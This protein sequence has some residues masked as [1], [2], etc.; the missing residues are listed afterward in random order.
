MSQLDLKTTLADYKRAGGVKQS[1]LQTLEAGFYPFLPLTK[2][3]ELGIQQK[4]M[5]NSKPGYPNTTPTDEYG[6][7]FLPNYDVTGE[8]E[9]FVKDNIKPTIAES[10][11]VGMDSAGKEMGKRLS[12]IVLEGAS[13]R[14]KVAR[15]TE[16]RADYTGE[17]A[18][19]VLALDIVEQLERKD[20]E[21]G[22]GN[23]DYEGDIDMSSFK[24]SQQYLDKNPQTEQ[25]RKVLDVYK[26]LF[27]GA[28]M[29]MGGV[30]GI[31][32]TAGLYKKITKNVG[33]ISKDADTESINKKF[34]EGIKKVEKDL[35]KELGSIKFTKDFDELEK[36]RD[37]NTHFEARQFLSRFMEILFY[38]QIG[39]IGDKYVYTAPLGT[40]DRTKGYE[41]HANY[42]GFYSVLPTNVGG[43]LKA[44]LT[45]LGVFDV[46]MNA[47]GTIDNFTLKL[48]EDGVGLANQVDMAQIT[49]IST[50]IANERMLD[51]FD[52]DTIGMES[53]NLTSVLSN[54]AIDGNV[55]IAKVLTDSELS[56]AL[57]KSFEAYASDKNPLI[58]EFVKS[59]LR[60]S[61][62]LSK[63]WKR[64]V[65][66]SLEYPTNDRYDWAAQQNF[67]RDG[68]WADGMTN[69]WQAS[70][71]KGTGLSISPYLLAGDL[72]QKDY[73]KM[74]QQQKT[75]PFIRKARRNPFA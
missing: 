3:Y 5:L 45:P 73:G 39:L 31:E 42:A 50:Q 8:G 21:F 15:K 57:L 61:N 19:E 51:K 20:I 25:S 46:G 36:I 49:K 28:G 32:E 63:T 52:S 11:G 66:G 1:I 64:R 38:N 14:P 33:T 43:Q 27:T 53:T 75:M 54:G 71:G 30:L 67:G 56:K 41:G 17:I 48:I 23:L 12:D 62:N 37:N 4:I 55:A 65:I 6:S 70:V 29:D 59:M 35:N 60:K 40:A 16:V 7:E 24:G 47:I 18:S 26:K 9:P 68:V 13:S 69:P 74:F 72:I 22:K 58:S 10:S 44:V 2:Q 34:A